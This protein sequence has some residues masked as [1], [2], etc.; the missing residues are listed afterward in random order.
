MPYTTI[1]IPIEEEVKKQAEAAFGG[2]GLDFGVAFTAFVRQTLDRQCAASSGAR[3]GMPDNPPAEPVFG[4]AKG[5]MW[6]SPDFDEPLEEMREY[7]E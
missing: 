1:S 6:I 2:L 7:R 4:C 3:D 5:K